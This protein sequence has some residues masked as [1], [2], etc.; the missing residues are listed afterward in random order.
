MQLEKDKT[1]RFEAK[2]DD[3]KTMSVN[4]FLEDAEGGLLTSS[5]FSKDKDKDS[6]TARIVHKAAQTGAY[7]VIVTT[8]AGPQTGKF[9][10][11]ITTD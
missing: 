4:L 1:Y 3:P 9:A 5:G 11:E 10:L 2:A 8:K 7:R 6:V